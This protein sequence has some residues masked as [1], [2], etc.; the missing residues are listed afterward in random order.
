MDTELI[1]VTKEMK[2]KLEDQDGDN[3]TERIESYSEDQTS[4]VNENVNMDEEI[5]KIKEQ[6]KDV[7]NKLTSIDSLTQKEVDDVISRYV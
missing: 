4:D 1:R 3:F 5:S 6:I 7:N 2:E